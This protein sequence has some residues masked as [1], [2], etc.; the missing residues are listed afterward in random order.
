MI[1]TESIYEQPAMPSEPAHDRLHAAAVSTAEWEVVLRPSTP[2]SFLTRVRGA[3]RGLFALERELNAARH[4]S[5]A[6]DD[7]EEEVRKAFAELR[8]ARR[9][10][11]GA[12]SAMSDKPEDL[13]RLPRV[14]FTAH[15]SE[16]RAAM[17]A[18]RFLAAVEGEFSGPAF[19]GFVHEL[20]IFEPLSLDELWRLPAFLSFALLEWVLAKSKAL[21]RSPDPVL[22]AALLVR[23]QSLRGIH[24]TDWLQ[25]I[26]PLIPFDPLLRSDPAAAFSLMDFESREMAR[27]QVALIAHHSDCTEM[28]VANAALALAREAALRHFDNPRVQ[29]RQSH[30]GYYLLDKGL[31][32]LSE[33]VGLHAPVMWRARQFVRGH[34]EDFYITG[35]QLFT[36]LL[37]AAI[38]LPV[39]SRFSSIAAA[40]AGAVF[41]FFPAMQLAVD[42]ANLAFTSFFTPRALSRLD[43]SRG[44]PAECTTLVAVPSMLQHE[45]Q[46]RELVDD[47]E[48]RFLGNRDPNLH[49]ALLTDLPDSVSKP[50][51]KDSNPLVELAARLIGEL[52]AKYAPSGSGSFLLLH[53]H[54]I[55][56]TRQGVWM[57]WE[58]KRGK[59]LDLNKL[60]MGEFDAFPIKAGRVDV[61]RQ[62]RYVLTVDADTQ[63]PRGAAQR[64]VG[65]LAHPLN[66]AIVDPGLRIVTEG[67]G[68]L[69]PR[70][71][72]SA[73]SAVRSRLA[74]LYSGFGGFDVYTRAVSDAY[75]DL[76]G[77]GIFTGKGIY[78]V[79]T[80]HSVLNHRFPR[81]S[82][83]SH[84]L[85][86]GAYVR[87]GLVTDVELID[88]Y[89]SHY[90]AYSRRKHRWV[91]GDWQ[92]AQW[93]LSTVPDETGRWG[94]NPISAISRWKI[95]DNLRR[96]LVE[97]FLFLLFV[98]G[99][100]GLPGGA[101]YWT[102]V[103]LALLLLP[104]FAEL[105]FA[106]GR[107]VGSGDAGRTL[108]TFATL[109]QSA[110]MAFLT[111]IFLP[112]Q[113]FLAFDAITR[114][115]L[116][117]FVT[118][119]RLMEWE[120]AAQAESSGSAPAPVDRYLAMVPI[121]SYGLA[122]AV[123]VLEPHSG[124]L[125]VAV[126]VLILWSLAPILAA[127]L[128]KPPRSLRRRIGSADRAF[129]VDHALHIWRFFRQF[130]AEHHHFL[131][132]DNVQEDGLVE[133]SH[134]SPTNIGLLLNARQAACEFGF[135]TVPEFAA[136]THETLATI[137]RLEKFRG[138]LYNWYDTQTCKP[139]G[140]SPFVSTVDSGNFVASLY[141]L[142]AGAV[143]LAKRPLLSQRFFSALRDFWRAMKAGHK[144]PRELSRLD[145]PGPHAPIDEWIA[146]LPNASEVL[147]NAADQADGGSWW[148]RETSCRVSALLTL[149]RD[150]LPWMLPEFEPL[151]RLKDFEL[152]ENNGLNTIERA[153]VF[154][155]LMETKLATDTQAGESGP[156]E[157]VL[158]SR[159]SALLPIAAQNLRALSARLGAVARAS[160]QLAEETEFAFLVDRG[161]SVLSIGYDMTSH[162]AHPALYDLLASEARI[163]SFLAVARGDLPQQSWFRLARDCAFTCGEFLPYSW[164]ATMFEYLMPALWMRSYPG[165]LLNGAERSAVKVQRNFAEGLS[166][167]WG[168]SESGFAHR[169]DAGHYDYKAFGVPGAALFSEATAGPVVAPYATFLAL[170]ADAGEAIRNL[171]WMDSQKWVGPYGF[172]ESADYIQSRR[173]PEVVREWM[174]HHTGMSLLAIANLLHDNVIQRWFHS[175]PAIRAT[176]L[177]LLETPP[178]K[179]VLRAKLREFAP[180]EQTA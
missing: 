77:E 50:H 165:T 154:C 156:E 166:L 33:R 122:A 68:I 90:S 118:G 59:L 17:V 95:F 58:R 82:L 150:Y 105:S 62:V 30:V 12:L 24:G 97:P 66:Q 147:S 111:L 133:A 19:T 153:I 103:A 139:L 54:R 148:I 25:V 38:F 179:S 180:L 99:W 89:P 37:L 83:L 107:A 91:R 120:T 78:E 6:V 48:V 104:S 151:R 27:K 137:A 1:P 86:E 174:A 76:F 158:H 55:F 3:R 69:Q 145:L 11:R 61:L 98:A 146:W 92:I 128:N 136:L 9:I 84:D 141:T 44:I 60:M 43:F 21:A 116:R 162:R 126:P 42:V 171:R 168:F 132:P 67:Y 47:L 143:D 110:R 157:A 36:L 117:R 7:A 52:N 106:F 176:E 81:N 14:V 51:D 170:A 20:Q 101:V 161:R 8:E 87:A 109:W 22:A 149:V 124:A 72:I 129:L 131:I 94:A 79:G 85:I 10:L 152:A 142:H 5:P 140:G 80:F 4:G 163:A 75:Q 71:G 70:I 144:L 100:F 112:H 56:N 115:L 172:Y 175:N 53:R 26:E 125:Y 164:T 108:D 123:Y 23:L 134:V 102:C 127:W 173:N 169:N 65:T 29:R 178:R 113:T 73:R 2:S 64:L 130:G 160:R 16:P 31:P 119:A 35:I 159:L 96:S 155:D 15:A 74:T 45:K 177:V 88:D 28:E 39:V 41:C 121:L 93:M 32:Q 114:T 167:P 40:L 13:A 18:E 63:L 49:F 46:L 135:L 57:G 34:S 138:H